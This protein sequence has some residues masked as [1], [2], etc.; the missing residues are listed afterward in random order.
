MLTRTINALG[1]ELSLHIIFLE[2]LSFEKK[3]CMFEVVEL[4]QAC[5]FFMCEHA[6]GAK[7]KA[8]QDQTRLS[9]LQR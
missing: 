6:R 2:F 4:S 7:K 3:T 8:S 9:V 5:T 1:R